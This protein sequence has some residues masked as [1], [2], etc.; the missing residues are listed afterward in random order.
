MTGTGPESGLER[1]ADD[2]GRGRGA[3]PGRLVVAGAVAIALAVAI[4]VLGVVWTVRATPTGI[5]TFSG[6]PGESV[7]A[8]VDAPGSAELSLDAATRYSVYLVTA[9]GA[10]HPHLDGTVAVTDPA[11]TTST[12]DRVTSDFTLT[13]G[14]RTARTA[15]AFESATAG[16]YRIDVPA[17]DQAG[18]E[19]FVVAYEPPGTMITGIVGGGLGIVGAVFLA[20]TGVGL[21]VGGL[22]WRALRR[23]APPAPTPRVA[24]PLY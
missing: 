16:R 10:R 9:A 24:P 23:P 2:G 15:G 21:L 11:G 3:G 4:G 19:A 18:A 17:A 8:V 22:V 13:S 1:W 12:L 5:L 14:D 7:L 20:I 6:A